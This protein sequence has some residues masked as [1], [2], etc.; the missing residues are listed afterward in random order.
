MKREFEITPLT[1]DDENDI[2]FQIK[3]SNNI[4]S[5]SFEFYGDIDTFKDFANELINFPSDLHHTIKFQV[6]KNDPSWA[7]YLLLAVL[8]VEPNGKSIIKIFMDNHGDILNSYKCSF[9]ISCEIAELNRIG[10]KLLNWYPIEGE[11]IDCF[12]L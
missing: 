11:M 6:G 2:F 9:A 4:C 10:Q 8:C 5:S 12:D 7:Y 1:V 3:F